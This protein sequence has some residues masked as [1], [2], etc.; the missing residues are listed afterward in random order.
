MALTTAQQVSL[1]ARRI[2]AAI[3]DIE[4]IASNMMKAQ[5][6]NGLFELRAQLFQSRHL[7]AAIF[8]GDRVVCENHFA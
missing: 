7:Q 2:A 5:D 4:V 1:E 8:N 6:I 3:E